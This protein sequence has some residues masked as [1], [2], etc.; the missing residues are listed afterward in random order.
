[1]DSTVANLKVVEIADLMQP[2]SYQKS[3]EI[4]IELTK[5]DPQKAIKVSQVVLPDVWK[6]KILA[7]K[8]PTFLQFTLMLTGINDAWLKQIVTQ[9][10]DEYLRSEDQLGDVYN[11]N[12]LLLIA[13]KLE[14]GDLANQLVNMAK[15]DPYNYM[16][17]SDVRTLSSF[18]HLLSKHTSI[19]G[20]LKK[21][22]S[23]FYKKIEFYEPKTRKDERRNPIPDLIKTV[24]L[25]NHRF[26]DKL[27]SHVRYLL[28]VKAVKWRGEQSTEEVEAYCNYQMATG[29]QE[30]DRYDLARAC[31]GNAAVLFKS[32]ENGVPSGLCLSYMGL[33]RCALKIDGDATEAKL[34]GLQAL[35]YAELANMPEMVEEIR[36]FIKNCG[37]EN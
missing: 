29:L 7:C 5:S 22:G 15:D 26:A 37:V 21:Y 33:A 24:C 9:L 30:M 28:N 10:P 6:Q 3:A 25:A 14:L 34:L 31:F 20:M 23:S 8:Y 2:L 36:R 32:I 11:F 27:L 4:L 18:L 19:E 35:N 17:I 16:K 12:R 1:M 13:Q